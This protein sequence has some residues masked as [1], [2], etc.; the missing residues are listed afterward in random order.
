MMDF[1][2]PDIYGYEKEKNHNYG[3]PI[4]KLGASHNHGGTEKWKK[5]FMN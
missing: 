1:P 3:K 4:Q 5:T 2:K